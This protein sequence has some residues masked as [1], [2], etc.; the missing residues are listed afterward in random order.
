MEQQNDDSSKT[1]ALFRSLHFHEH[2]KPLHIHQAQELGHPFAPCFPILIGG[3]DLLV[4]LRQ[5]LGCRYTRLGTD[6]IRRSADA[7]ALE[8]HVVPSSS[9]DT[10]TRK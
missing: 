3:Q 5:G 7:V 2:N 1:V 4:E 8:H 10:K 6:Q 9:I